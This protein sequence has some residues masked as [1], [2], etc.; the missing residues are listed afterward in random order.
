VDDLSDLL[1]TPSA[2]SKEIGSGAPSSPV[3]SVNMKGKAS[4]IIGE[5]SGQIFSQGAFSPST[6]KAIMYWREVIP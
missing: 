6:N 3:I 1:G 4:V 5:T 2:R